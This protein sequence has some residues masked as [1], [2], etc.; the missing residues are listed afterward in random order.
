VASRSV[1]R[2]PTRNL[3]LMNR[4]LGAIGQWSLVILVVPVLGAASC[5]QNLLTARP[6][7]IQILLPEGTDQVVEFGDGD[8][9][10]L[11]LDSR[12]WPVDESLD[13]NRVDVRTGLS[14][15]QAEPFEYCFEAPITVS[16]EEGS[17]VVAD[18]GYCVDDIGDGDVIDRSEGFDQEPAP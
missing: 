8:V 17:H 7:T 10:N 15:S 4:R 16:S 13:P 6:Y 2:R 12:S 11:E 9:S 1:R 5:D 3:V 18:A 14:V